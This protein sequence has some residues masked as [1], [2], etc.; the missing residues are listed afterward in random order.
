MRG[1][2]YTVAALATWFLQ[3][4]Q[5]QARP[6]VGVSFQVFYDNLSPYGRWVDD[7]VYGRIWIPDAE[8]DFQPYASRGH[9]VQTAYGN[10]WVSEYAWGWA[11]FHYGRWVLDDYYGWA[12]IPGDEWGPGWVHWRSG[13][14]H[15]GWA[16]MGPNI[17]ISIN[18]PLARWI[19]VPQRRFCEPDIYRYRVY[20]NGGVNIYRNTTI[21]NN[22]YSY[23]NRRY[24]AG[25]RFD[26]IR[27]VTNRPVRVYDVRDNDRPGRAE[28]NRDR[29]SIYRPNIGRRDNDRGPARIADARNDNRL[30]GRP[31]S[32]NGADNRN[33]SNRGNVSD[34]DRND[35]NDRT[36]Q[37]IDWQTGNTTGQQS[38]NAGNGQ[39]PERNASANQRDA[40]D[41]RQPASSTSTDDRSNRERDT[42]DW[43]RQ[44]RERGEQRGVDQQ[45]QRNRDQRREMQRAD[46]PRQEQQRQQPPRQE[47]PRVSERRESTRQEANGNSGR[48][49]SDRGNNQRSSERGGGGRPG[50]GG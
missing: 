37:G 28:L 34:R 3:P 18:F 49:S 35:R 29:V 50:R 15:Y 11:P 16:P 43:M 46:Q 23:N 39:R 8:R 36:R 26:E 7:R 13:G 1:A 20:G 44:Q 30:D 24:D 47:Q 21:I 5:T 38:P 14:G 42:N 32:R 10:T 40:A 27:R 41:N 31:D 6:D 4:Q 12:W 19:F 9:W 17:N 25:P 45:Q 2:L 22:Y 33:S 48:S